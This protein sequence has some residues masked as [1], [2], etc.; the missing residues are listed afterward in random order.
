MILRVIISI[1]LL[2][3]YLEHY[4]GSLHVIR[5]LND[6]HVLLKFVHWF[7]LLFNCN[8]KFHIFWNSLVIQWLFLCQE[9]SVAMKGVMFGVCVHFSFPV[10]IFIG[11]LKS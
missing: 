2:F 6:T 7:K 10:S 4:T 11:K 9:S 8:I 1:V 3:H 5:V